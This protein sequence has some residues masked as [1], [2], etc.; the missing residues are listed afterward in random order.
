[1]PNQRPSVAAYCSTDTEGSRR[2]RPTSSGPLLAGSGAAPT[3]LPPFTAPPIT[4]CDEPQPWSVPSL[5]LTSVRPK[6]VAVKVVTCEA[7][8]SASVAR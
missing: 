2:P 6:S 5:L 1:M 4:N 7:T 3:K 8:P